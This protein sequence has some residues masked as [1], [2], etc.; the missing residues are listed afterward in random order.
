MVQFL[1]N[2]VI[3]DA[4]KIALSEHSEL[5]SMQSSMLEFAICPVCR[6]HLICGAHTLSAEKEADVS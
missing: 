4:S 1:S 5:F 3:P 6:T 2:P